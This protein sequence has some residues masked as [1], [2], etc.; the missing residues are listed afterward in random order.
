MT[1]LRIGRK[2]AVHELV[3]HFIRVRYEDLPAETVRLT[4]M[5][6][7]DTLGVALAAARMAPVCGKVID[8]VTDLG[9]RPDSTIIGDGRR[10]PA[11]TAAL[12][13]A[14]LAHSLNYDDYLDPLITHFGCVIF[15]AAFAMAERVGNVNGKELITAY[16][17][18]VD[19]GARLNRALIT[20]DRK[21]DWQLYGWLT[22]QLVGY[23]GAAAVAGRLQGLN[24]DQMVDAL[25]LAYSQVAGNKQPLIGTG[26]D[27]GIYPCYPAHSGVLA[28]MMAQRGIAGPKDSLEG[29]AGL[30]NVFFQGVYD[31]AAL[32]RDLGKRFESAG[33]HIYPCCSFT[34]TRIE[35]AMKM[36]RE[37]SLRPDDIEAIIVPAGPMSRLLCEPLQV[38]RNPQMMAEAQYSVP[39]T[40]AVAIAKGKPRIEHFST[41]GMRDAAVLA[42]S[43]R[44]SYV[45]DETY[46]LKHGTGVSPAKLEIRLKDGRT[47]VGDQRGVRYGHPERPITMDDLTEKFRECA[48]YSL[49]A[50]PAATVDKVIAMVEKLEEVGDVGEIVR[51]VS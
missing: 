19:L 35:L 34:H 1:N 14:A 20:Q 4:K 24:R 46:D 28:A 36:V 51:L 32:T 18:G 23:F 9:G 2:D 27:K 3:D 33:F 25:G 21:R 42:I 40:I 16:A 50:L 17:L 45:F 49:R 44:V 39:F 12:A 30:F 26:A 47:V 22:T 38:R 6:I 7:L 13:N 5:D 29:Q 8:L 15:P 10:V 48:A 11:H 31:P 43:N 41:E 37:H